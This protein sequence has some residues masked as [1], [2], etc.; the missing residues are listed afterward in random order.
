MGPQ[1]SMRRWVGPIVL[2]IGVGIAYFLAAR[3][4]LLLMTQSGVAVFWP[5]AGIASGT[6]IALGRNARWP[7]AISVIAANIAANLMGD[8][9]L[10]SSSIFALSDAGEALLVAWLFEH[11]AGSDFRCG[12]LRQVLVLL[13]AAIVGAAV[14]GV[15]GTLGYELAHNSGTSAWTVWRQW[16]ASDAIG[17]IAV[18]PL[19][20]GSVAALRVPPSRRELVEGVVALIA[21]AATTGIIIF[22]LPADW[23][24]MCVAV[25]LL[26]PVM[27]WVAAR[28]RPAVATAAVF[29][30]SLIVMAT[31]TF[32]LGNYGIA[33]PSMDDSIISAQITIVGTA[34]CAFILSALFAEQ[35]QQE[36]RLQEALAAGA[37]MA[38]E[39]DVSTDLVRRSDDAAQILGLDPQQTLDGKTFLA[40]VHPDDLP[41]MKALWSTLNRDNSTCSITYR[42]LR[43]DGREVWLQ[44]TSKAEFDAAGRLAGLKGL[45]LDITER[46]RA[47]EHQQILIA[48]LDHRVKNVLARVAAVANSTGYDGCSVDEFIRSYNGR[49]QS[50]AAAH[51]LLSET[52]WRGT[53]LA[54]LVRNQLAPYAT[55]ANITIA[56]EGIMLGVPATQA[57][58]MVVHELVTNAVKY[59]AL[60]IPG[61]RV[62]VSWERKLNGNAATLIL[63]WREVGGPPPA[64]ELRFGYGTRLIQEL[65]PY[66]LAG[67]VDL[68]FATEGVSCKIEFPIERM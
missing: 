40:R 11:Y 38:F 1:S 42:F 29:I 60:S 41:R 35:R 62:L 63:A 4:S 53:D 8:R 39:W 14:S 33:A 2:T 19:I 57:L 6:L 64:A 16:F 31:V 9:N 68:M 50:M 17:I 51:T 10:L 28:C 32:K 49:I 44:E 66:E 45:A 20:I 67:R 36:R 48:E 27:L 30:V 54:A 24:E 59:G 34:L 55:H 15:G 21:V 47:E 5:A 37:V 65:V 23:W 56:G 22:M 18:A 13:A 3:L 61:G 25:V 52:S 26:F 58:A 7:V 46:K 12:L 43:L